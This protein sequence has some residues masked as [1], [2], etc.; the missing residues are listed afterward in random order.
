[1]SRRRL[2]IFRVSLSAMTTGI[3]TRTT[4]VLLMKAEARRTMSVIRTSEIQ[5]PLAAALITICAIRSSTPVR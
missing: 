4:A 2:E 5:L 1:M 3:S